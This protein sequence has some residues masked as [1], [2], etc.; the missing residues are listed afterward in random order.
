MLLE[1]LLSLFVLE[2][3][4]VFCNLTRQILQV[5]PENLSRDKTFNFKK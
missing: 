5:S 4:S 1:R 2:K 3:F